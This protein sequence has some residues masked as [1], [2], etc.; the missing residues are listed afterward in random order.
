MPTYNMCTEETV[1]SRTERTNNLDASFYVKNVLDKV[2]KGRLDDVGKICDNIEC[3]NTISRFVWCAESL[4]VKPA[5]EENAMN[6][7]N[8]TQRQRMLLVKITL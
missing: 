2:N 7:K 5:S 1:I 6:I 8:N 4:C 3:H